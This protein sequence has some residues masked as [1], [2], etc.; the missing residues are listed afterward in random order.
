MEFTMARATV[1]RESRLQAVLALHRLKA[2]LHSEF[3]NTLLSPALNKTFVT[4]APFGA[5]YAISAAG[6]GCPRPILSFENYA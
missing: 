1:G 6:P 2:G 5:S 3:S 4:G